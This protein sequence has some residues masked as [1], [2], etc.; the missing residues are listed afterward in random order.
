MAG[1]K[2]FLTKAEMVRSENDLGISI[3]A[4]N[5]YERTG[6]KSGFAGVTQSFDKKR[7]HGLSFFGRLR[8]LAYYGVGLM[9][10]PRYLNASL[11]DSLVG[12]F[13]FYTVNTNYIQ[14]FDYIKWDESDVETLLI[15]KYQWSN[16]N[17]GTSL[18]RTGDATAAF[19]NYLY[20]RYAGFSEFDTFRSNQVR[21]GALTRERALELCAKENLVRVPEIQEY[22]A[23]INL[24][25]CEV[26]ESLKDWGK[27]SK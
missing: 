4:M 7:F 1:D 10:N 14:I 8:L 25:L 21:A 20:L 12:F 16:S 6:F 27:F 5:Q 15:D 3:F 26:M 2:E 19:Y 22:L 24:T 18:W 23:S 11:W 9:K 13:S 17:H